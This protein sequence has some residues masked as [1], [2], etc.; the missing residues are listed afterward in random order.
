MKLKVFLFIFL[1][2]FSAVSADA[3]RCTDGMC[4]YPENPGSIED[5]DNPDTIERVEQDFSNPDDP[6][7]HIPGQVGS[8]P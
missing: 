4:E 2:V 8:F 3:G 7:D 5:E 6:T 1:A